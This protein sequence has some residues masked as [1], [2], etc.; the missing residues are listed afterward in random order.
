M[1]GPSSPDLKAA[2]RIRDF[3][4]EGRPMAAKKEFVKEA[5][6]FFAWSERALN[7]PEAGPALM[8]SSR[9]ASPWWLSGA[10]E[11]LGDHG[12]VRE[13]QLR[14]LDVA[15]EHWWLPLRQVCIFVLFGSG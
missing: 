11:A 10:A 1:N 2:H 12:R 5:A 4:G 8:A 9:R 7:Q 14:T 6:G 15:V 3:P 13:E